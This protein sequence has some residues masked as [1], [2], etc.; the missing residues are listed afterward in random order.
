MLTGALVSPG[1]D[2]TL[3]EPQLSF[4]PQEL[5]WN[6]GVAWKRKLVLFPDSF[7]EDSCSI[8][9]G[10][11]PDVRARDPTGAQNR[12]GKV[13]LTLFGFEVDS[14][15]ANVSRTVGG[16]PESETFQEGEVT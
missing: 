16:A 6:P 4:D 13:K 5:L 9:L 1:P 2:M 8:H 3:W 12:G 15:G 7:P 10:P 11:K 14:W